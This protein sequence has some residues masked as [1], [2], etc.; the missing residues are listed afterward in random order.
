MSRTELQKARAQ[1]KRA[2]ARLE[3]LWRPIPK[4]RERREAALKRVRDAER[5]EAS[6]DVDAPIP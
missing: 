2:N 4:A 6:V 3:V 5:I 1:L